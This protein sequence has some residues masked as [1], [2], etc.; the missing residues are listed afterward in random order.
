MENDISS[1][2]DAWHYREGSHIRRIGGRD[3]RDKIQVRLPMGIEQYEVDGRPDGMRPEGFESYLAYYQSVAEAEGACWELNQEAFTQLYEE[4]LLYY[5]RYLLFFQLGEYDLCV[6]DTTR[7]LELADF[8]AL[9]A[10]GPAMS[11]A[12]EQYRPY[13]LRMRAVSLAVKTAK[14]ADFNAAVEIVSA[15]IDEIEKLPTIKTQ[16]FKLEKT[17]SLVALRDLSA[18]LARQERLF[19]PE[20]VHAEGPLAMAS[21]CHATPPSRADRLKEELAKAVAEENY[22]R[23]AGIR[24]ELRRLSDEDASRTA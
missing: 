6:R 7:N 12:I 23:A 19:H 13:I 16:I 3:G 1:I 4:G 2:L 17:R 8:V 14:K 15:A 24:D 5:C 22:E 20:C 21:V 10:D 18:Q 11:D 9:R